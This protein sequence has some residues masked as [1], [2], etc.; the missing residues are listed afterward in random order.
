LLP[1]EDC[2]P[3][4]APLVVQPLVL[5]PVQFSVAVSPTLTVEDVNDIERLGGGLTV[6]IVLNVASPPGPVQLSVKELAPEA[7]GETL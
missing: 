5:L 7:V 6:I 4:Q 3:F 2:A 1:C